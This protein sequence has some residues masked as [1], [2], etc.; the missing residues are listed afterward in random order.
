M[1]SFDALRGM[2]GRGMRDLVAEH[3]RQARIVP[4]HGQDARIDDDLSAG[5]AIG[6]RH[7][8][9]DQRHLPDERR[10]VARGHGL[11]SSGDP[12]YTHV[13]RPRRNDPRTART[14]RLRVLLVAELDLLRVGQ[15]DMLL[16]LRDRSLLAATLQQKDADH[17]GRDD[18]GDD[19][20]R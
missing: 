9:A 15:P 20:T 13:V 10:L 18:H 7:L 11:D 6:V 17:D 4:R 16:A 8:L 5:Q 19:R 3:R 12:L 14:Q 1:L 2:L